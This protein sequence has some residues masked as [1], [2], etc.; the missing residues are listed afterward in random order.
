M[1][2]SLEFTTSYEYEPPSRRSLT[3]LRMRPV[4]RPG[5]VVHSARVEPTPGKV[6]TSYVD[7]FGT[8]VDLVEVDHVA[9]VA[10]YTIA[11]EVTT[12]VRPAEADLAPDESSMYRRDSPHVPLSAV[13]GWGWQFSDEGASWD[14]V[15][16]LL[17]WMPQRF[18][19]RLGTTTASTPLEDFLAMGSGVCQD[20]AH[21]LIAQLR[22]WGWAARYVSGYLFA[23]RDLTTVVEA[24]AMHAWVEVW[25]SDVGWIGLDPTSGKLTDERYIPV[26]FARDYD[27][28]RPVRGIVAGA[29][30]QS[31]EAHLQ[32]I[33]SAQ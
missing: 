32:V 10:R 9:S 5:L 28:L 18:L 4:T 8:A 24:E 21:A 7:G 12:S 6:V 22:C 3:A 25:R 29:R 30:E 27:D 14:A 1:R 15:E 31:Q 20:F 13:H 11:A 17:Q 23:S 16:S 2:L 33:V 19:F 26:G